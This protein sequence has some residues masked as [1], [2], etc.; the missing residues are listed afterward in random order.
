MVKLLKII[1]SLLTVECF[2]YFS[3]QMLAHVNK[4]DQYGMNR[5]KIR[6]DILS[7]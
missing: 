1:L 4:K 2:F 5:S 6:E 7:I 3:C